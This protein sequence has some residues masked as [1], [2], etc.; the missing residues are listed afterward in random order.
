M[1]KLAVLL[2]LGS[3][4]FAQSIVFHGVVYQGDSVF[5]VRTDPDSMDCSVFFS[6]DDGHSWE[7]RPIIYQGRNWALW[8][9]DCANS[10]T[11]WAVGLSARVWRTDDG[12]ETWNHQAMGYLKWIGRAHAVDTQIVWCAVGDR[13]YGKTVDGVHWW[14]DFTHYYGDID[15]YGIAAFDENEAWMAGGWPADSPPGGQGWIA[16]TTDGGS[17]PWGCQDSSDVYD[18]LDIYMRD[19]ELGWFVGGMSDPPYSPVIKKTTDGGENWIE[20]TPPFGY[21]LRAVQFLSDTE[22]W[23]C[24]RFGTILHTLDGGETWEDHSYPTGAT[25]F[26]LMFTSG[27]RG[28][29][30]GDS[31][32]ILFTEDGGETWDLRTPAVE[33]EG[34]IVAESR[35]FTLAFP[36]NPMKGAVLFSLSGKEP[37]SVR[38]FDRKGGCVAVLPSR[39]GDHVLNA[40]NLKSGT[41]FVE[42]T[43]DDFRGVYRFSY[44]E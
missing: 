15:Y 2:V 44:V 1:R 4:C 33:E 6:E 7:C 41:Y 22:G 16:H 21:N 29:V 36:Q 8:D 17:V 10:V 3:L 20:K 37:T 42:I 39:S 38:V 14:W 25:L 32:T 18:Y 31:A 30:V 23:V 9:L 24:G 43:S 13:S 19:S 11:C 12:G 5:V 28:C 27:Q 35:P 40:P 26:D 34:Q